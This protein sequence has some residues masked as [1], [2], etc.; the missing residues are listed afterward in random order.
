M[1]DKEA[2]LLSISLLEA[3]NRRLREQIGRGEAPPSPETSASYVTAWAIG[4]VMIVLAALVGYENGAHFA[5]D[6]R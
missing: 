2:L 1:N 4:V 3:A 6:L 5:Y